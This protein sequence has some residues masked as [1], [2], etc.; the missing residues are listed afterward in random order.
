MYNCT[1]TKWKNRKKEKT[2]D[3]K[4][5]LTCCFRFS[6]SLFGT[7]S[8]LCRLRREKSVK[9]LILY[10]CRNNE[11]IFPLNNKNMIP[12][13]EYNQLKKKLSFVLSFVRS[14]P[15]F[16]TLQTRAKR[17]IHTHTHAP[18]VWTFV[19]LFNSDFGFQSYLSKLTQKNESFFSVLIRC[20]CCCWCRTRYGKAV[21]CHDSTMRTAYQN[22]THLKG[23][24]LNLKTSAGL[25]K[26]YCFL[27]FCSHFI[28]GFCLI[29]SQSPNEELARS[30]AVK[31]IWKVNYV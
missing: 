14:S 15:V 25:W 27:H 28:V 17:H 7:F 31:L 12:L 11:D 13:F 1:W 20:C 10:C 24:T 9:N 30:T 21:S 6:V 3:G 8:L 29:S 4:K 18:F 16:R 26:W 5:C 23:N 2:R 19:A 22:S